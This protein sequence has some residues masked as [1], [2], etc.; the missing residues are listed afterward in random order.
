MR[1]CSF[2]GKN[3]VQVQTLIESALTHSAAC[4]TCALYVYEDAL[5]ALAEQANAA[6]IDIEESQKGLR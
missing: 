1:S 4:E 2:C 5:E 3:E 6:N